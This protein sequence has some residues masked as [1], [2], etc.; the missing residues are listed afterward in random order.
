MMR[1]EEDDDTP[2]QRESLIEDEAGEYGEWDDT[3]EDV[4]LDTRPG[5]DWG[6]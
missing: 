6:V 5:D 3:V 1:P 2:C 4:E